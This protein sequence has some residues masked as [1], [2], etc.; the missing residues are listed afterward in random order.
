M[1]SNPTRRSSTPSSPTAVPIIVA[2]VALT[3][4]AL[5]FIVGSGAREA[6]AQAGCSGLEVNAAAAE[7]S[8]P[9]KIMNVG[10]RTAV[11]VPADAPNQ[12]TFS[13]RD[14]ARF[15]V[16]IT[17]AG[18]Y[19][20]QADTLATSEQAD[21]FWVAADNGAAA[22]WDVPKSDQWVSSVVTERDGKEPIELLLEPG[23]HQITFYV[24]ESGTFLSQ[25]SLLRSANASRF[26]APV[27]AGLEQEAE[28]GA[29][30]GQMLTGARSITNSVNEAS[31]GGFVAAP[32][33]L[34]NEPDLVRSHIAEYCINSPAGAYQLAVRALAPGAAS[35]S[36]WVQVNGNAPILWDVPQSSSWTD[37]VVRD[38]RS[39]QDLVFGLRQGTNTL[40]FYQ[41]DSG[42]LLDKFVFVPVGTQL[43]AIE[44]APAPPEPTATPL[45]AATRIPIATPVPTATRIPTATPLPAATRI[46]TA[47]PEPTATPKPT[48][49]PEP[50][51]TPKPTATRVPAAT[52]VPT[53]TAIPT[54]TEL[55]VRPAYVGSD[56]CVA[57]IAGRPMNVSF[58][59]AFVQR[60]SQPL[61]YALVGSPDGL[62]PG[63]VIDPNTGELTSASLPAEAADYDFSVRASNAGGSAVGSVCVKSA[64]ATPAPVFTG[65]PVTCYVARVAQSFSLDVG[66]MFD[67]AQGDNLSFF[68]DDG[69]GADQALRNFSIDAGS[70]E[71][72]VNRL[73]NSPTRIAMPV[74][75]SDGRNVAEITLCLAIANDAPVDAGALG[76]IDLSTR[77][78]PVQ[79]DAGSRF[80]DL[81]GDRIQLELV[82]GPGLSNLFGNEIINIAPGV[83]D[84]FTELEVV[85]RAS[86][87]SNTAVWTLCTRITLI[88]DAIPSDELK[89]VLPTD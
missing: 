86:D 48:A 24:R 73:T 58:A 55:P 15:C 57:A 53:A 42:T 75:V 9:A 29:V 1:L 27:C 56:D 2:L 83:A 66:Q 38:G 3:I 60:S 87:G 61:N 30:G 37:H 41:R 25:F 40:R 63:A 16:D 14:A 49:T 76:C 11:G 54:P 70:G 68:L 74:E 22:L 28:N 26:D 47:T 12:Y 78:A 59:E 39:G 31:G 79:I 7:V 50:T 17:R 32:P 44:V 45:P 34:E 19:R 85:L 84:Y 23:T 20:I 6:S 88:G 13:D 21:S 43:D 18:V 89:L 67:D 77:G 71:I 64:P 4:A 81:A 80:L 46:P 62:P 69:A 35:D 8:G 5:A 65:V 33:W 82:N 72:R 51:A 10:G 36:F 52:P